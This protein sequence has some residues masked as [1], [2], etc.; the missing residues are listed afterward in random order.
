MGLYAFANSSQATV[1]GLY[2]FFESESV[3]TNLRWC[4]V[5]PGFSHM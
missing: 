3:E 2:F 4:S 5:K 1:S